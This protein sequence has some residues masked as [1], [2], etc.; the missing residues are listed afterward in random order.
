MNGRQ[1]LVRWPRAPEPTERSDLVTQHVPGS[2]GT[3]VSDVI[4]GFQNMA[5]KIQGYDCDKQILEEIV[6]V[7]EMSAAAIAEHLKG[8]ASENLT[9]EETAALELSVDETHG[10]RMTITVGENPHY[11]AS[12]W[13]RD[14]LDS[15]QTSG[16]GRE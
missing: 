16:P 6:S 15:D 1:Y 11:V 14:E 8:L 13:R 2:K 7:E 4:D 10:K 12:L 9:P 3:K 5:W